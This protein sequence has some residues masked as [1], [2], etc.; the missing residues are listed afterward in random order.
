MR[1][2]NLGDFDGVWRR[3]L[4]LSRLGVFLR[5]VTDLGVLLCDSG[6][7]CSSLAF[8]EAISLRMSDLRSF[9]FWLPPHSRIVLSKGDCEVALK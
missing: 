3:F 7:R 2:T 9:A 1:R 6:F 5:G 4:P 8:G